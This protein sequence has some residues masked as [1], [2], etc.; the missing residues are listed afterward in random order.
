VVDPFSLPFVQRGLLEV[1][2]LALAAGLLGTWI[3]LRGLAFYA[4]AVGTAAFPGLVL[5]AGLGFSAL[6]GAFATAAVVAGLVGVLARR[7][8]GAED[9]LTALVLVGALAL[10]VLL[11]SD[12]FHSSAGVDQLLFGSLLLTGPGDLALA[13]VASVLAVA[14]TVVLGPRWLAHGFDAGAARAQGLRS[15]LPDALLLAL[16]ALAAV[17][18][19]RIAGALLA[20][21]LIVVPAAT[22]RLLVDRLRPWQLA[23]VALVIVEGAAGLWVS[24]QVNAPPGPAIAVLAGVLFAL[25]ALWRAAAPRRRRALAAG[26]ALAVV[27]VLGLAAC[28]GAGGGGA[29]DGRLRVVATTPQV[30]DFVREVG[31]A[32][33]DL[34]TLLRPNTDPHQYEPRPRDVQAVA[35]ADLVVTSGGDVD[36]WMG[37]VLEQAGGSATVLPAGAGRPYARGE[38]H[39][40]HD[41]RNAEYAVRRIRAVLTKAADGPADRAAVARGAAAYERRLRTL[42]AGIARCMAA[43]PPAQRTMV[44][45]HDAFG[46]FAARYG[47]RIVGAVIPARTTQAQPS[48]GELARLADVIRRAHVRAVFPETSVN[49]RLA[50]AIARQTGAS[51]RYEL[52]GDTLGPKGSDGATYVQSEIHN[53]DAM[54][55]GFTGG[56]RGCRVDVR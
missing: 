13:A 6:L 17:A 40:W 50:Q 41:P 12:V 31:G 43:V 20:T 39:W 26:A 29:H 48:A 37:N 4:H 27:A 34:T 7:E 21:A 52:Y 5:A 23:T 46:A 32:R 36:N 8:R 1:V 22:T 15:A 9:T 14:G 19:L 28:G 54:L 2:A 35:S 25:A 45:D 42:D 33:I 18:A 44:T 38:P 53:A 47:V 16:V 51:S 56:A 10:G 11:S 49:A 3:V 30:G 55:R 24:V